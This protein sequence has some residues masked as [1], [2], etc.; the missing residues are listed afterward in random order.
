MTKVDPWLATAAI[1]YVANIVFW[2]V[3]ILMAL[4]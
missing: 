2:L 4:I 3:Y 1:L